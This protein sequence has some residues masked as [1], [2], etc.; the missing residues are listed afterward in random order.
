M[1]EYVMLKA[2]DGFEL[3]AYVARPEGEPIAGLVVV[4]EIFGIN[5]HIRS[6]ADG[7]AKDGFLAI[8]PA[9]FDRIERGVELGYE[10]A[11]RQRAM[12]FVPKLNPDKSLEDIAAAIEFLR[13]ETGK[14]VGV[15]GY[16]FG[17]TMAWL[18]TTRLHPAVAVGY[19]GGHIGNYAAE[20]PVAPVMLHFGKLDTH[21]PASVAEQVKAAHPEVEIFWYD[22]GHGF[23]CDARDSYNA[24]AAQEARARSLSFL[25]KHLA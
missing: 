14:K 23:N 21:I 5:P 2:A 10:G 8:A 6:V 11:D 15:I 20:T 3:N 13:A 24:A 16:C 19:Y 17:G 9:L 18:S 25:T 1:S 7:Y 4:Q 22:A 12:T